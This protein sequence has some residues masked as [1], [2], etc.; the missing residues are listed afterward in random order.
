MVP[1]TIRLKRGERLDM[2]HYP[3]EG[4]NFEEGVFYRNE[5]YHGPLVV[6]ISVS[7]PKGGL[8]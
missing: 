3:K 8:N 5:T 4:G 6:E 7:H 2:R 1:K